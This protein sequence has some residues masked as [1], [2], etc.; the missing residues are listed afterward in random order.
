MPGWLESYVIMNRIQYLWRKEMGE[1]VTK[2]TKS[3]QRQ[4]IRKLNAASL[5][6]SLQSEIIFG[7]KTLKEMTNVQ[8]KLKAE[9]KINLGSCMDQLNMWAGVKARTITSV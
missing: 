9:E 3:Q 6:S 7:P 4:K 5:Q 1:G 8:Q 2:F